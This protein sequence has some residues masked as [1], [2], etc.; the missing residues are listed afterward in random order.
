MSK[1]T[2]SE[3]N[4]LKY[5]KL[6]NKVHLIKATQELIQLYPNMLLTDFLKILLKIMIKHVNYL[7]C[8]MNICYLYLIKI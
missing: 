2:I 7:Y 4:L 5:I 1:T 6:T 3:F 8:F